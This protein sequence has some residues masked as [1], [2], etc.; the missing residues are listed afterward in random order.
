M[1]KLLGRAYAPLLRIKGSPT[2]RAA[3]ALPG[4]V[5]YG[6]E[7]AAHRAAIGV[8]ITSAVGM[9]GVMAHVLLLHSHFERTGTAGFVQATSPLYSTSGKDFLAEFFERPAW[10]AGCRPLTRPAT[11][12]LVHWLRAGHI[13]LDHARRLFAQYFRPNPM[14][15]AA[16]D[17]AAAGTDQFDF[18][19][20]FRGT[21][22]FLESGEVS[23]AQMLEVLDL[24]LASLEAPRIFLATDDAAFAAAI[25]SRFPAAR[26]VSYDLGK[27]ADGI[28][29][30]FSTLA[31]HEK[32][33][34][35]AVNIFLLARAKACVR[36]SSFLSAMAALANPAMRTVTINAPLRRDAPFPE[37][38]ILANELKTARP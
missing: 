2:M 22:K 19:V 5:P 3:C 25:R 24:E 21:D 34:E 13:E 29:R 36:T 26:F 20:H 16:V 38:E 1:K 6:I 12:F 32:A 18:S 37:A 10:P 23:Y 11:E 9:G 33:L 17:A 15:Q 7:R 27:V 8:D 14:L 28:P 30:H 35:A 31:P 4:A